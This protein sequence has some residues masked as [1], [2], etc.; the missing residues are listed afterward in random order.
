MTVTPLS[1][2]RPQASRFSPSALIAA[3]HPHRSTTS[4]ARL[5]VQT[6]LLRTQLCTRSVLV[7]VAHFFHCFVFVQQSCLFC[8]HR[9]IAPHGAVLIIVTATMLLLLSP[10][11]PFSLAFSVSL[12]LSFFR[13]FCFWRF[14]RAVT[15][16]GSVPFPTR[17]PAATASSVLLSTPRHGP[18]CFRLSQ[19]SCGP[20]IHL[21]CP[22]LTSW[23]EYVSAVLLLMHAWWRCSACFLPFFSLIFRFLGFLSPFRS[24]RPGCSRLPL[25]WCALHLPGRFVC[26]PEAETARG[27]PPCVRRCQATQK[28]AA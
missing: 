14:P 27:S 6:R 22:V 3:R 1:S 21:A 25:P 4:R 28:T 17:R 5:A 2:T 19:S 26:R 13:S 20:T 15:T 7:G 11:S 9:K 16:V 12:S 24:R 18:R 8:S 23:V 10:L